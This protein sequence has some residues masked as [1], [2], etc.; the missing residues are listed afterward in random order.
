MQETDYNS[1]RNGQYVIAKQV[2][3]ANGARLGGLQY[4]AGKVSEVSA[5]WIKVKIDKKEHLIPQQGHETFYVVSKKEYD[6]YIKDFEM[7]V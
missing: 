3:P 2:M 6:A 5:K 4:W 7:E 1:I